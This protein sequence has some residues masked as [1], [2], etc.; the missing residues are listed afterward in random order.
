MSTLASIPIQLQVTARSNPP[1]APIDLNTGDWPMAY[2]AS[3]TAF[4][5]GLFGPDGFPLDLSNLTK[6]TLQV[7]PYVPP[8][9]YLGYPLPDTI[10]PLI[11]IDVDAADITPVITTA[12]W[13]AAL[14]KNAVFTITDLD[15]ASLDLQGQPFNRFVLTISGTVET[16]NAVIIYASGPIFFYDS[17][18]IPPTS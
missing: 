10:T 18:I 1:I 7:F 2:K 9:N 14:E 3:Q 6:L 4:N 5:V 16:S 17:G 15:T 13:Q 11:T 8:Q 12:Q